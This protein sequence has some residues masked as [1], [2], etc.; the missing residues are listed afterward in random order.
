MEFF[1]YKLKTD[2]EDTNIFAPDPGNKTQRAVMLNGSIVT[3]VY[4][5]SCHDKRDTVNNISLI[6]LILFGSDR[7]SKCDNVY[8][9]RDD[10]QRVLRAQ[11][12]HSVSILRS[13]FSG[14]F[15]GI[16]LTFVWEIGKSPD[17]SFRV[18]FDGVPT[19]FAQSECKCQ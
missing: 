4:P 14:H 13:F 5:I 11:R 8:M 2:D 10:S 1:S 12:K 3:P 15:K 17:S 9:F 16:L 18:I 19:K 6:Y 7:S